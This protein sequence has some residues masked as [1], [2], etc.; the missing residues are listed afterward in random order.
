[1]TSLVG[2]KAPDFTSAAVMPDGDI[3]EALNL[4]RY[5]D[6]HYGI[7]F[8]YPLNFTFVCPSE[9]LA[10]N[11]RADALA[12]L[13]TKLISVSVDSQYSHYAWRNTPVGEGGLGPVKFP[14]VADIT[15][16]IARDYGVLIDDSVALRATFLIDRRGTIRQALVNDLPLG[17]DA[18]EALRIV[19]ALR[20]HEEHGDVCPAGWRK[21]DA[22]MPPTREGV[23]E[24]LAKHHEAL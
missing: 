6:G 9:I 15:K 5:L 18:D 16:Q 10:Y 23:A 4:Y 12:A 24:Y 20:F 11:N 8:F 7:L 17:R 1:M 13:D 22:G 14:M 19:E 3:E 21:G 2:R